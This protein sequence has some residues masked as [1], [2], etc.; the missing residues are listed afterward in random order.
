MISIIEKRPYTEPKIEYIDVR[1]ISDLESKLDM[2]FYNIS[3]GR[4]LIILIKITSDYEEPNLIYNSSGISGT[5]YVVRTTV[6]KLGSLHDDDFD[7]FK[8]VVKFINLDY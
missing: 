3:I 2:H 1:T 5:V 4:G 7:Y 6:N 8:S